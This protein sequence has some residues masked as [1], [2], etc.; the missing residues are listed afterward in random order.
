[1]ELILQALN[2]KPFLQS[3]EFKAIVTISI[4]AIIGKLI[5]SKLVSIKDERA[6][7]AMKTIH[8]ILET[9]SSIRRDLEAFYTTLDQTADVSIQAN[10]LQRLFELSELKALNEEIQCIMNHNNK[11]LNKELKEVFQEHT[12][13]FEAWQKIFKFLSPSAHTTT[14]SETPTIF[15]EV[16]TTVSAIDDDIQAGTTAKKP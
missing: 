3:T 7:V 13:F 2:K 16:C 5:H 10:E 15:E 14:K 4:A 8:G 9:K 1:M 12:E 11:K 6:R